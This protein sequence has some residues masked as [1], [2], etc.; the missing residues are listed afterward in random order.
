MRIAELLE[1]GDGLIRLRDHSTST[2]R[3]VQRAAASSGVVVPVLPGVYADAERAT[4]PTIRLRAAC[5]W[6]TTGVIHGRTA[7]QLHLR[8]PVSYPLRLRAAYTGVGQVSWL[9]VS[10]STVANPLSSAG[11]RVTRAAH[12]CVELA[13][14]DQ[15]ATIFEML[16]RGLVTTQELAPELKL[17]AGSPGNPQRARIVAAAVANPWSFGELELHQ[18]LRRGRI[19]GWVANR[20]VRVRGHLLFPDVCFEDSRLILEFDGEAVHSGHDQF[21]A[22]RRRQN[23]LALSGYRVLR[24]TWSMV[25]ACPTEVLATVRAALALD[26]VVIAQPD[27]PWAGIVEE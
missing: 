6:S 3:L 14:V 25:T 12:C 1:A 2:A 16:R 18:L 24:F 17:F 15:G 22:D 20:G 13:A 9:R 5:L 11:F 10:H 26:D 27:D 23:L 21:E 7:A 4:T 8:Q 19:T